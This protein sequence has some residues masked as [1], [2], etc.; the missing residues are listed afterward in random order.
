MITQ[1]QALVAIARILLQQRQW[2]LDRFNIETA[3]ILAAC[4][5]GDVN[6]GQEAAAVAEVAQDGVLRRIAVALAHEDPRDGT[7]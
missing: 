4:V 2:T 5:V 1:H 6:C 7:E 3:V